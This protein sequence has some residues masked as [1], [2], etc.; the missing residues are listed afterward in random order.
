MFEP[1]SP[2]QF[3]NEQFKLKFQKNKA[4]SN[5]VP[6]TVI[7][8]TVV[9]PVFSEFY[10]ASAVARQGTAKATKY[11]IIFAT[12]PEANLA[13]IETITNDLC[14]DHQIVFQ[15]VSLPVPLFIAGRCSQR[16]A[17]VLGYN[18]YRRGEN[19]NVDY[20]AMNEQYGYSQK[21]LFGKRFNA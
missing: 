3:K 7:D 4:V 6:G 5:L 9:S 20:E 19:G 2:A 11:T 1:E 21:N 13:R 10:L 18:G 17:A 15:P 12:N 14:F 16:G 8:H